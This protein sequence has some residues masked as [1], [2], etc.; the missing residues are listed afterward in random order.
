MQLTS[1]VLGKWLNH[2]E[3]MV[4]YPG[5]ASL[6]ARIDTT[7]IGGSADDGVTKFSGV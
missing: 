6:K 3:E 1:S 2:A 7:E 4:E 5:E